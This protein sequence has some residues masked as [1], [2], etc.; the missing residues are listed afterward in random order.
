LTE[1][2]AFP[3]DEDYA[4]LNQ[5]DSESYSAKKGDTAMATI[6]FS[7]RTKPTD[8]KGLSNGLG[9]YV[10]VE[11]PATVFSASRP[12]P[13][14]ITSIGGDNNHWATT[15]ASSVYKATHTGFRIYIRW[16]DGGPLIPE[17]AEEKNW[18]INWIGRQE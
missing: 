17:F 10:N 4:V 3:Y 7:G 8:W 15:G 16:I 6:V 11:I 9:I 12:V 1:Q 2:T 18:H 13:V 14:F 5:E